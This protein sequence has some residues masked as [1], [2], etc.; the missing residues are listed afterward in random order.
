MTNVITNTA[1]LI[2]TVTATAF[3]E[4]MLIATGLTLVLPAIAVFF[5]AAIKWLDNA[6]NAEADYWN[7]QDQNDSLSMKYQPTTD[8]FDT[9]IHA[10]TFGKV[11]RENKAHRVLAADTTDCNNAVF[12]PDTTA[13]TCDSNEY[14]T[15]DSTLDKCMDCAIEITEQILQTIEE[16]AIIL[17]D[18]VEDLFAPVLDEVSFTE[19]DWASIF[20]VQVDM[21]LKADDRSYRSSVRSDYFWYGKNS[22]VFCF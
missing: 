4:N 19:S 18:A 17:V 20:R 9:P 3:G 5:L 6:L 14:Q 11:V 1:L 10:F 16:K 13:D 2:D 15:L 22:D 21:A 12:W 8:V 7:T